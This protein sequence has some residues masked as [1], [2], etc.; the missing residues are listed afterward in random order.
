MTHYGAGH[1]LGEISF[2][3][4]TPASTGLYGHRVGRFNAEKLVICTLS[5]REA[6][7]MMEARPPRYMTLHGVI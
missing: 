2:L 4:G 3:L 5:A 7:Q 6:M 1:V